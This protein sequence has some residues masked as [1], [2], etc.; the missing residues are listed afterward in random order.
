MM[1]ARNY[2]LLI[3]NPNYVVFSSV[4]SIYLFLMTLVVTR[5]GERKI[6]S[7]FILIYLSRKTVCALALVT[8]SLM[9]RSCRAVC[10][11]ACLPTSPL[12]LEPLCAPLPNQAAQYAE[13]TLWRPQCSAPTCWPPLKLWNRVGLSSDQSAGAKC[14]MEW[15]AEIVMQGNKLV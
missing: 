3:F 6:F 9:A 1:Q 13:Q 15:M 2:F 7:Q 11:H 14:Q 10:C 5:N 8:W 4:F 12:G